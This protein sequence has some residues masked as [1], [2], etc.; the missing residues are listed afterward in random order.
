MSKSWI[1]RIVLWPLLA[2]LPCSPAQAWS[3]N[4]RPKIEVPCITRAPVIDGELSDEAWSLAGTIDS[5]VEVEPLEGAIPDPQT[6]ILLMRDDEFLYVAF[7]CHEPEPQRL[8]LQDMHRDGMQWE[9]DAAKIVIDTF[10]DGKTGYYF[11]ISAAGSRLDSLVADNG[12]STNFQW[13]GFWQA[14]AKVLHD[15][16]IAE[17]A[18][19]F[20]TLTFGP[21]GTW[22][23][24]FERWRG[25]DRSKSRWTGAR[26]EFRVTTISEGGELTNMDGLEQGLGIEFLPYIKVKRQQE[27]DPRSSRTKGN[28]GGELSLRITPQLTGSVTYNTDFAETEADSRRVN[29]T[30]FSLFFPEKR[31]FFLQDSNLFNFGWSSRHSGSD[32]IPYFSRRIG[33]SPSGEEIP[34]EFGGRLAGRMNGLDL[35]VLAVRTEADH[36]EGVPA[37]NLFVARPAYKVSEELTV[38]GIL[39]SG[40]PSSKDENRVGGGDIRFVSTNRLPGLFTLNAFVL[41]SDDEAI[42]DSGTAYGLKSSLDT[43]EWSGSAEVPYTQDKFIPALG[44]VRRPGERR[45][46]GSIQWEPRPKESSIRQFEFSLK[47]SFWTK[48]DGTV[49][50]SSFS[51]GIFKAEWHDGDRFYI[52]HNLDSDRLERDFEPVEGHVIPTGKHEWQSVSVGY[53][54]SRNRPLS[55][56]LSVSGGGWYNGRSLRYRSSGNWNPCAN[57]ALGLSYSQNQVKLRGGNFTTRVE[58]LNINYDFT[59]NVRLATLVQADNIS[60]NLGLQSRFHLI[61]A[62]GRELYFVVNSSWLEEEDGSLIPREQD[63]TVKVQYAFRF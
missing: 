44:F 31:D 36:N 22:R 38:G 25:V 1:A 18:I 17:F 48:P 10:C 52:N 58:S 9:D 33:L 19:P 21:D 13:N 49:I 27:R 43:G 12:Q 15:R 28:I 16:W 62:D 41:G 14:E 23:A 59:P 8:V 60:D 57:L 7:I 5:L 26:Q 54:F 56:E 24:N 39:T 11:L 4:P 63:F 45:Y 46:A 47:P 50:S 53:S 32:L 29:L 30:R 3:Q 37:G 40:N 51:L 35:G 55:G 20:Q 42:D 6:E 2:L 61:H 34:I